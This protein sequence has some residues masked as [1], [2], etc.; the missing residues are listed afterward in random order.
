LSTE[1]SYYALLNARLCGRIEKKRGNEGKISGGSGD[2]KSQKIKKSTGGSGGTTEV[3]E[4][5][6]R[7]W[8]GTE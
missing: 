2:E 5:S 4:N 3:L 8:G 6:N 1:H 7:P